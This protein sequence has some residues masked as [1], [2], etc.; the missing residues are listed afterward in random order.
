MNEQVVVVPVNDEGRPTQQIRCPVCHD[1]L[2]ST[3]AAEKNA[4]ACGGQS[5]RIMRF[6]TYV[7][8]E[9]TLT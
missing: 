2:A 8:N 4:F 6:P 3:Y 1:F 9:L 7:I 5:I